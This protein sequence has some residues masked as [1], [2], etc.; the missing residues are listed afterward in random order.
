MKV[1]QKVMCLV[2][3]TSLTSCAIVRPGEVGIKQTLGKIKSDHLAQ[4]AYLFNPFITTV[5]KIPMR[6]VEAYNELD[7]PTKEGLTVRSEISLLYHVKP[8]A[9]K[10]VYTKYGM[11]Y[12]EIIVETNFRAVV[13][14]ICGTYFAKELFAV[15]RKKIEKEIFDE[16]VVGIND[17]GFVVDAVLLKEIT[18]P[19]QI[20]QAVENKLKSEQESLQM[21]YVISKQKKEAERMQIE[22]EAIKN[23][24]KTIAESMNEL[25]VKWSGVQVLKGL[26]TSNNSKV[27]I[28][29]GKSPMIINDK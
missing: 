20:F 22:A 27:I 8:E 17:K 7:V 1:I 6:T 9:A 21:E 12:Q 11:N 16:L 10:E 2:I 24:N 3:G 19:P 5:K 29:D 23:Y 28:T 13:R 26:V 14:H 15:D 25:M 18:M 4:G